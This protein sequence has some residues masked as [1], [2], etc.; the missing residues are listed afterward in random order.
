MTVLLAAV[1][2][3]IALAVVSQTLSSTRAE[4]LRDASG[5]ARQQAQQMLVDFE[6]QLRDR[7]TSYL[8]RVLPRERARVCLARADAPVVQPGELWPADCGPVWSYTGAAGFAVMEITPPSPTSPL[9]QVRV[10]VEV[11]KSVSGLQATYHPTASGRFTVWSQTDLT[12]DTLVSGAGSS[13]VDGSVYSGGTIILPSGT[14][15]NLTGSQMIAEGGFAGTTSDT[16]FL[17]AATPDTNAQPPQLP[18]RDLVS[19]PLT[20]AG[21]RSD[22]STLMTRACATPSRVFSVKGGAQS[23]ASLCFTEGASLVDVNGVTATVPAGTRSYL[24]LAGESGQPDEITVYASEMQMADESCLLRCSLTSLSSAQAG[25]HPG[26]IGS[27]GSPLGVFRLPHSGL[28]F[29]DADTH[30]G[31]CGSGFTS[32]TGSCTTV[33]GDEPGMAVTRSFTVVTGTESEPADVFLSGPIV[34]TG[35]HRLA[36]IASGSVLVPYWSRPPGGALSVDVAAVALGYGIDAL[37]VPAFRAFPSTMDA[38][39]E[40]GDPNY[41]QSL[42]IRGSVIAPTVDLSLAGFVSVSLHSDLILQRTP[43]PHLS[44]FDLGVQRVSLRSLTAEELAAL[45]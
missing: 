36:V 5:N 15:V 28:V 37:T 20:L 17:Y 12:M 21:L 29:F 4:S 33:S 23:A 19:S 3:S 43:P 18:A 1:A 22:A 41:A 26:F 30:V 10:R 39:M 6:L 9:L 2:A 35:S 14:S 34:A 27:W 13:V 32:S 42:D 25:D 40:N 38:P 8:E 7:P 44:G 24:L 31:L 11:G 45:A 16:S